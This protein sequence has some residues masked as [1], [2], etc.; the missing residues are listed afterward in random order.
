LDAPDVVAPIAIDRDR[1]NQVFDNLLGNAI[2]FSPRGGTITI[3]VEDRGD[4]LQLSVADM[5]VGIPPDKLKR[6]F[7][8]FYQVDGSATRRFGGAGLGLAI[9]KR[10]VESHGGEIWVESEMGHGSRFVFTLPKTIAPVVT[11]AD[12][13]GTS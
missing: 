13:L 3:G 9:A 1:I 6:I 12:R 5:G 10:I 8:R 4:R 11:A 7:D 2:K